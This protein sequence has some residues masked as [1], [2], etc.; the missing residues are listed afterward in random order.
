MQQN[1]GFKGGGHG[2]VEARTPAP[3]QQCGYNYARLTWNSTAIPTP[4]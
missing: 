2:A 4:G 1:S 3:Q